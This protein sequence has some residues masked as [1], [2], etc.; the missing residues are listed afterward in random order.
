MSKAALTDP[1]EIREGIKKAEYVKKGLY[2][3]FLFVY[4]QLWGIVS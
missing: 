4:V 3:F 1:E 2:S